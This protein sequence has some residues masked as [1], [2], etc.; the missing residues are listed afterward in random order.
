MCEWCVCVEVYMCGV[1]VWHD[2]V[3]ICVHVR[4]SKVCVGLQ[5]CVCVCVCVCVR[6][7]YV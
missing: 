1:C 2:V 3:C 4:V 5:V 7:G 6:A